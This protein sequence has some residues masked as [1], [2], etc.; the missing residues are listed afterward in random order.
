LSKYVMRVILV[1]K[2]PPVPLIRK[3]SRAK[4]T[5][6]TI[7]VIPTFSSDHLSCF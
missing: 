2:R 3:T 4:V 7:T 1:V 6:P 5:E